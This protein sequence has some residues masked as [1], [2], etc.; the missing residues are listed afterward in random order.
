MRLRAGWLAG[1]YDGGLVTFAV[2][3]CSI[4]SYFC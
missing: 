4:L 3:P 2:T 1:L